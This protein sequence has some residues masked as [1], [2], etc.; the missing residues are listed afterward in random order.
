[1]EV[2]VTVRSLVDG[3]RF[4]NTCVGEW[5]ELGGEYRLA[6]S[7]L[8]GNMITNNY[9]HI[10]QESLLLRREGG[11]GGEMLFDPL[12]DTAVKYSA[13]MLEHAFALHT[14]AYTLIERE[15]GFTISLRYSLHDGAAAEISGQQEITVR[16]PEKGGE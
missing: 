11:F 14:D 12:Y 15:N 16:F 2:D 5:E 13:V 7:D 3:A 9:L 8:G 4:E 10:R 6:Y 1:M